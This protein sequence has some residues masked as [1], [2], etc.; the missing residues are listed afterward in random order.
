MSEIQKPETHTASNEHEHD[1]ITFEVIEPEHSG[2]KRIMTSGVY[3]I[4]NLI[5]TLSLFSGFLFHYFKHQWRLSACRACDFCF[6]FLRWYGRSSS[7]YV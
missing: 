4:P 5:T 3:L 7:A 1:G 6:C 2:D